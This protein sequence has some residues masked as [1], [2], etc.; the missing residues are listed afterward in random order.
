MFASDQLAR[1]RECNVSF[2]SFLTSFDETRKS[3][4]RKRDLDP[5]LFSVDPFS[6]CVTNSRSFTTLNGSTQFTAHTKANVVHLVPY[7]PIKLDNEQSCF[8]LL[9]LYIPWPH[10]NEDEL[11]KDGQT[12][13]EAW[14]ELEQ[15]HSVPAFAQ[16]IVDGD[17]R[18]QQLDTGEPG[19]VEGSDSDREDCVRPNRD[20]IAVEYNVCDSGGEETALYSA[21]ED[22]SDEENGRSSFID[23]D[24]CTISADQFRTYASYI[25][26]LNERLAFDET[27]VRKLTEEQV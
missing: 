14:R 18:R 24:V 25:K 17:I 3:E 7:A 20:T 10:G 13:V 9:L 4:Q 21:S 22:D 19:P 16:S 5:P 23:E 2:F 12:A 1:H 27:S 8:A 6:G 11:L 15:S 26:D